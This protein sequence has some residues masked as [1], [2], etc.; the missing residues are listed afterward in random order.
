MQTESN[1]NSEEPLQNQD[2]QTHIPFDGFVNVNDIVKR[3]RQLRNAEFNVSDQ[4]WDADLNLQFDKNK[5]KGSDK[6][7]NL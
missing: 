6:K 1:Q 4:S 3:R 7:P 2:D 5:E